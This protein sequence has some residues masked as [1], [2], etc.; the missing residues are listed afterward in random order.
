M[1]L[2]LRDMKVRDNRRLYSVLYALFVAGNFLLAPKLLVLNLVAL[3]LG[4]II[5]NKLSWG[6]KT[7]LLYQ[8][9]LLFS[10]MD[11]TFNLPLMG[12]FNIYYLHI[13]L[14]MLTLI[15][16]TGYLK[17]Y[18]KNRSEYPIKRLFKHKYLL[19]LVIFIV[20]MVLSLTWAQNIKLG[21][22]YMI[23]YA[24]MICFLIAVYHFNRTP[25]QMKDSLKILLYSALIVLFIGLIE[26]TGI[27][28]L[29]V[30]NIFIDMGWYVK[31]PQYLQTIPTVFFYNPNNYATYLV[32][33]MSFIIPLIAFVK[34]S[35]LKWPLL[36]IQLVILWSLICSTS[37]TGWLTMMLTLVGF[38]LF[39]AFNREKAKALSSV[40][41][42]LLTLVIFYTLSMVPAMDVY[43]G[44]FNDTPIFNYLTFG[45]KNINQ[46]L[47]SF[48]EEGS[49]NQRYT[50]IVDI[51]KGV[52]VEGHI[53]GFGVANTQLYLASQGNTFGIVNPHSLWFEVLGDFGAFIFLYLIFIYLNMLWDLLKLYLES[54]KRAS[55]GF[56][57][58]LAV[59]LFAALGGF[60][61]TAFAPSSVISFTQ[62]WLLY[63]LVVVFINRQKEFLKEETFIS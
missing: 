44:K 23:N 56:S 41:V 55:Y 47:F 26:M 50:I 34:K 57:A 31:G 30:R 35:G 4:L 5:I 28:I 22:K 37:R 25:K 42:G 53:Q 29:Q 40:K 61:L 21:I 10:V 48:G 63:G 27:R 9:V 14:F 15:L 38:M 62:M 16:F 51:V 54:K 8:F 52:F 17:T 58:Y 12:R 18:F 46:P 2:S 24:I 1:D 11:F 3:V 19:F 59:S 20:Y 33:L 45:K 49:T 7:E 6:S 60:I 36:V 13:A 39:F 32:M 43:Y